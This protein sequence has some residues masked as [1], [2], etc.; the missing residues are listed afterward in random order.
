[1][2]GVYLFVLGERILF[3]GWCQNLVHRMNQN[4]GTISPRKCFEGSEPENCLIN[5]RIL[6]AAQ[7]KKKIK[8]YVLPDAGP[9]LLDAII[10]KLSPP[11][12]LDLE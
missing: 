1:M 11:W 12:N 7:N 3:S 9:D 10:E 8:L 2:R 6:E 5:S 4:Y